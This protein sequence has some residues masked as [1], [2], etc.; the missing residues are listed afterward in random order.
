MPSAVMLQ[1]PQIPH[2]CAKAQSAEFRFFSSQMKQIDIE[3]TVLY[4]GQKQ[5]WCRGYCTHSAKINVFCVGYK[6][7]FD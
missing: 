2:F 6:T 7:D 4:S 5:E 3:Y 1:K